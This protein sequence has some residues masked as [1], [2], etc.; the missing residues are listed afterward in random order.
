VPGFPR[1]VG[2]AKRLNGSSV[3]KVLIREIQSKS[4]T[5]G[6]TV[7]LLLFLVPPLTK[8]L[9]LLKSSA[10]IKICELLVTFPAIPGGYHTDW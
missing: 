5:I 3:S 1:T 7:N 2:D 8:L 9:S 4:S 10:K 6:S